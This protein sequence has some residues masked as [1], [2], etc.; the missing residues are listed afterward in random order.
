MHLQGAWWR[1]AQVVIAVLCAL[2]ALSPGSSWAAKGSA[3]RLWTGGRTPALALND[4]QRKPHTLADYRGKVVVLNF[5]ATW[6][7]PCRDEMPALQRL[8]EKLGNEGLVVLTVD[9]GDSEEKAAAFF[10]QAK[11]S[12]PVLFDKDWSTARLLWKI[13]LLP[14]TFI[15]DRRGAIRY[16]VLGE[17]DWDDPQHAAAIRRLLGQK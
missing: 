14:A 4:A 8:Q 12:L 16:S 2:A 1:R 6:C 11:L 17:A 7:E 5:W 9:V 13:R 10:E 15:I 3:L